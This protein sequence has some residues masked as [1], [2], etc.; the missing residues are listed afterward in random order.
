MSLPTKS[1][2]FCPLPWSHI[3][4]TVGG[5]FKP[6]CNTHH[7]FRDMNSA[8]TSLQQ[9]FLSPV[10]DEIRQQMSRGEKPYMCG[11][12]WDKEERGEQSYR[13]RYQKKFRAV[14]ENLEQPKLKY[15]DLKFDNYCNLQCRMCDP[16]SS[17]QISKTLKHFIKNDLP[18]P[19]HYQ[20]SMNFI[21]RDFHQKKKLAEVLQVL[22][23]VEVIKITGG[24]PF[25]SKEF[26]TVMDHAIEL[27]LASK[28]SLIITTN[29]T[30][31]FDEFLDRMKLFKSVE[32]N[33]SVDGAFETYD[34]IRYP[35]TWKRWSD[36]FGNLL[37]YMTEKG[38]MHNE[39]FKIRTSTVVS[40]YN[41]L[42]VSELY[43]S[44]MKFADNYPPLKDLDFEGKI[45]FNL[46]LNPINSE[47][48]CRNL[49]SSLLQL[50][51]DNIKK[52]SPGM[53]QLKDFENFAKKFDGQQD[54]EAQKRLKYF[55]DILDQE[56][57]QS[58]RDYLPSAFSDWLESIEYSVDNL[59]GLSRYEDYRR[60]IKS[61]T[62]G[63]LNPATT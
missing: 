31:F 17:S 19:M 61:K 58:H 48:H 56:R 18:I 38:L 11:V 4:S 46:N 55:T 51:V 54:P 45:S 32:F 49:P 60:A 10:V 2:T 5:H 30:K 21:D 36:R 24:E 16:I 8:D 50:G 41:W 63:K 7:R 25:K 3:V 33:V 20:N 40:V 26:L 47:M 14:Y 59:E 37:K 52:N 23:D 53:S 35:F 1:P 28:I 44:L 22:K 27:D 12:C 15:L 43:N 42:A 6:C 9:A 34:Y 62:Y 39:Q 13:K 57:N 29:G